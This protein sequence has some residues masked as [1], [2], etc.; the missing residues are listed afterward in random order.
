MIT[1]T[2]EL[3]DFILWIETETEY[4]YAEECWHCD[5]ERF[6][7]VEELYKHYVKEYLK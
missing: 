2:K 6:C 1:I 7:T 5:N 4:R 3:S